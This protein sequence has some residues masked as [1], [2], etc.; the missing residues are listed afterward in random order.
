LWFARYYQFNHGLR[1]LID[2]RRGR[3]PSA[4]DE[5]QVHDDLNVLFRSSDTSGEDQGQ[6]LAAASLVD[7]PFGLLTGGPGTGKTTSLAKLLLLWLRQEKPG[8][9]AP[10]LL[11][12]PTGKA[13][14]RLRQSLTSAVERLRRTLGSDPTFAPL[15]DLLNPASERC[16][17]ETQTIHRALGVRQSR[18]EGQGPFWRGRDNRL[19][20]AL[21]VVDEVSMVD[22][23]LMSRLV[24]AVPDDTPLWLVGDVNQ[25]ESVEAGF[26]LPEMTGVQQPLSPER[27]RLV[28]TRAGLD[29]RAPLPANVCARD[30]VHLTHVHR[31]EKGAL[32]GELA[33]MV[34]EGRA[35]D[36]VATI[37]S[38]EAGLRGV[39]WINQKE[40]GRSGPSAGTVR[41]V[42]MGPDGY[43]PLAD[44]L[45]SGMPADAGEAVKAFDRF[46]VLC[47]VRKGPDGVERWNERLQQWVVGVPQ[48]GRARAVML[49]VN[50]P[51]SGLCN[52][53]T[54]LLMPGETGLRLHTSE[55]SSVLASQLPACEPGWAITIH[56]SQGSE[57]DAVAIV[58][59]RQGGM[60]LSN[61]RLLYT[62][63]TRARRKVFILANERALRTAIETR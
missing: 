55:G 1:A 31:H 63:L 21:V 54:G 17:V 18:R 22:L 24:D 43:G 45:N 40:D 15:L 11:C 61:R 35:D 41:E 46:R 42:M 29:P 5:R 44:L 9:G 19:Q 8:T 59:P 49:I 7:L 47:A 62:A 25:L 32:V 23:A 33:Q 53:D 10:I 6:L 28:C 56:K 27:A 50:D 48:A 58:L 38:A 26:A 37:R 30:H 13:T 20:R 4:M 51:V 34:N 60:A 36:F 16:R 12:A 52:G 14:S 39:V 2:Q 3:P 57:F